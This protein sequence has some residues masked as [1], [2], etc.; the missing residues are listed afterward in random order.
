NLMY[1]RCNR[2]SPSDIVPRDLTHLIFAF[3]V[4][5]PNTFEVEPENDPQDRAL[6]YEFT[7]LKTSTT[8]T[9]LSIGGYGFS[10]PGNTFTTWSVLCADQGRRARF[11]SSLINFMTAWE[12]QGVDIDWEYPVE[13]NRGGRPI[14][15]ANLNSLIQEMRAAFGTKFGISIAL[16]AEYTYI[17]HFDVASLSQ[18]IDFFNFMTYDLHGPWEVSTLGATLRASSS[19]ADIG[20]ALLPLWYA[21]VS[22]SKI[23]IGISMYGRSY[24]LQDPNCAELGCAYTRAGNPGSCTDVPGILSLWEIALLRQDKDLGS[25]FLPDVLMEQMSYDNQYVIFDASLTVDKK[26][27]WADGLCLGG[28]VYWG[29]DLYS[30]WGSGRTVITDSQDTTCGLAKSTTCM[31]LAPN[32]KCCSKSGFCGGTPAHCEA[33]NGCQPAFGMCVANPAA[34]SLDGRCGPDARTGCYKSTFGDCCSKN[35]YCGG[36][37]DYCSHDLG[38]QDEFGVCYA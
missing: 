8:Q 20:S 19:V 12:F 4:I 29:V 9:W 24:T 32:Q 18:Y 21:N 10:D 17:Q 6:Y 35:G 36:T 5:N 28:L 22:P 38:C 16:P 31:N 23:N 37:K 26:L 33:A 1:R 30:S 25:K 27:Q 2:I 13:S 15:T 11:I 7:A 3:V 14:D 34:V